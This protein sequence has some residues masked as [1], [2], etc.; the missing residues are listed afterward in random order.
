[1][2]CFRLSSVSIWPTWNYISQN[3]TPR[4]PGLARTTDLA[5]LKAEVTLHCSLSTLERPVCGPRA[6][7][8]LGV[9]ADLWL[10]GGL[11]GGRR[12]AG[13]RNPRAALPRD[14]PAA[15]GLQQRPLPSA[16]RPLPAGWAPGTAATAVPPAPAHRCITYPGFHVIPSGVPST[17]AVQH[18]P[19]VLS[20]GPRARARFQQSR[21]SPPLGILGERADPGVSQTVP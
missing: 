14:E 16:P 10:P 4:F 11:A 5:S 18:A 20:P 1:M 19:L 7:A 3:S 9:G 12:A 15:A 6:V 2:A 13:G 17:R 8:G 21:W